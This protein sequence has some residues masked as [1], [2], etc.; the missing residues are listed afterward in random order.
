MRE[1]VISTRAANDRLRYD[2]RALRK[3]NGRLRMLLK[4]ECPQC[5]VCDE[6]R[7]A[8]LDVLGEAIP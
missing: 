4:H 8:K 5:Q 3:Q 6:Q 2:V 7:K 1:V